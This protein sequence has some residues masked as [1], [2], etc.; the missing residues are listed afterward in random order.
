MGLELGS[1]GISSPRSLLVL[2]E[3]GLKRF[4]E[5]NA[6]N[7][8]EIV[9]SDGRH[10]GFIRLVIDHEGGHADFMAISDVESRSY[11]TETIHSVDIV[12]TNG[13]LR[14]A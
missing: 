5:L 4:D 2:G 6:A 8:K 9:W 11:K 13:T 10:R 7:N 14:Y 1:T 12:N 3:E